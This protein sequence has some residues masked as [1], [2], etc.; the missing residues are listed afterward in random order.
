MSLLAQKT[1][2]KKMILAGM[3]QKEIEKNLNELDPNFLVNKESLKSLIRSIKKEIEAES[4]K[5]KEASKTIVSAHQNLDEERLTQIISDELAKHSDKTDLKAVLSKLN[6]IH[7]SERYN[8]QKMALIIE[9][10]D[11]KDSTPNQD[12]KINTWS[13]VV[14]M[15]ACCIFLSLLVILTS[16]KISKK[17]NHQEQMIQSLLL[18]IEVMKQLPKNNFQKKDKAKK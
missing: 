12:K 15:I 5:E 2:I 4:E 10:I 13:M 3:K 18:E 14:A 8:S 1:G 6:D 11:S 7:I 16:L 9:K 17:L